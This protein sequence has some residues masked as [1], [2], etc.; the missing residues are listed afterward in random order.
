MPDLVFFRDPELDRVLGVV[1]ELAQEVYALRERVRSLE[2]GPVA[3]TEGRDAYVA[4]ILQPLTYEIDSPA[5]EFQ[6]P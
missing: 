1:L 5:P 6:A 2:G 4:R 3:G